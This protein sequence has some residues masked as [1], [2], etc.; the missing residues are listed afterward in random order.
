MSFIFHYRIDPVNFPAPNPTSI[1]FRIVKP[2][3][4]L[5]R[6]NYIDF[7]NM[8]YS[9]DSLYDPLLWRSLVV[10]DI[11]YTGS[12]DSEAG[13]EKLS[14]NGIHLEVLLFKD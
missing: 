13:K 3:G 9:T 10:A 14:E 1:I 12:V 6:I 5:S 7:L 4:V 11:F 8:E 2:I